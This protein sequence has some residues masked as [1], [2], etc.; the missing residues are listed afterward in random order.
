MHMQHRRAKYPEEIF[1]RIDKN[2]V[3]QYQPTKNN[4]TSFSSI[5]FLL[6]LPLILP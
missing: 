4:P 1:D 5:D 3:Y 2:I 6:C